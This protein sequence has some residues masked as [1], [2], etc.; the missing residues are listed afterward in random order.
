MALARIASIRLRASAMAAAV[1][2]EEPGVAAV[3]P[4]LADAATE[5]DSGVASLFVSGVAFRID[6]V[7]KDDGTTDDPVIPFPPDLKAANL[8]ATFA[9]AAAIASESS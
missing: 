9:R 7:N 2:A 6:C 5:D 4:L 8:A 3:E 1:D